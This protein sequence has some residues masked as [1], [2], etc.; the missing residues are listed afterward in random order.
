MSA[1]SEEIR[2]FLARLSAVNPENLDRSLPKTGTFLD[3]IQTLLEERD[4]LLTSLT[5]MVEKGEGCAA[6]GTDGV[7]GCG[8]RYER[9]RNALALA[10]PE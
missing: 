9:A 1:A 2:E 10:R 3:K 8:C 6:C 5:E 7:P 4:A